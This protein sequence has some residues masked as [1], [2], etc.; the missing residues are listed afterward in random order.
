V[1]D[2]SLCPSNNRPP[3]LAAPAPSAP[4]PRARASAP[5]TPRLLPAGGP[6]ADPSLAARFP[7]GKITDAYPYLEETGLID[8]LVPKKSDI[9]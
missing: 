1:C 8:V 9:R 3:A 6:G 2:A 4:P 7:A 5:P